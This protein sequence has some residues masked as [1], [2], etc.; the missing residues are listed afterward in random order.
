MGKV[1]KITE[2]IYNAYI[3]G[4]D[5]FNYGKVNEIKNI[6]S[7]SNITASINISSSVS[8]KSNTSRFAL[9]CSAEEDFGMGRMPF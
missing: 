1:F 8:S 3:K 4:E 6:A 7:Q 5:V 9:L 2:E